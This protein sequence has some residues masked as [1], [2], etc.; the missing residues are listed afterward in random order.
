[1]VFRHKKKARVM[2]AMC[3]QEPQNE[4]GRFFKRNGCYSTRRR[5]NPENSQ[6]I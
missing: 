5:L 2:D 3:Q 6:P 4:K 1:V